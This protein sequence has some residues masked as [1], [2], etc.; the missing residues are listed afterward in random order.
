M[1]SVRVSPIVFPFSAGCLALL[2]EDIWMTHH[3][4]AS[5]TLT[6]KIDAVFGT[7]T[8]LWTL[9]KDINHLAALAEFNR[10]S[11]LF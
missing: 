7:S 6:K 11:G 4:L 8:L 2:V 3:L 5:A 1:P 9:A 10:R